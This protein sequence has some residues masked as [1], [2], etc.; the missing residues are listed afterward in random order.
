MTDRLLL[1]SGHV[2]SMDPDIGE[3][4]EG[5]VLI[6]DGTIV[7]GR[8]ARSSDGTPTCST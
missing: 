1:R 5:D 3:L 6:E 2:I 8:S 4:P 7:G